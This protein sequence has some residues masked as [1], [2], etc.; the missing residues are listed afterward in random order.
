LELGRLSRD[1][2]RLEPLLA[3]ILDFLD[4]PGTNAPARTGLC[5]SAWKSDI[6]GQRQGRENGPSAD[7]VR[8]L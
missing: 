6:D 3:A 7:L 5:H 1:G 2:V 8:I 4:D